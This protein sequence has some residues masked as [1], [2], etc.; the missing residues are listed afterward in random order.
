MPDKQAEYRI[1]GVDVVLLHGNIA[2]LPHRV[3]VIVSSDD[4]YLS[5]GG[6][7]SQAIWAAA[8]PDFADEVAGARENQT[9][10]LGGV[11]VTPAGQLNANEIIHA[12]TIDLDRLKPIGPREARELYG[13]VV[14]TACVLSHETVALP[15]LGTGS[16]RLDVEGSVKALADALDERSYE[17]IVL[18]RVFLVVFSED[19]FK[20]CDVHLLPRAGNHVSLYERLERSRRA[21]GG[22]AAD[23]IGEAWNRFIQDED[24]ATYNAVRLLEAVMDAAFDIALTLARANAGKLAPASI[25][26]NQDLEWHEPAGDDDSPRGPRLLHARLSMGRKLSTVQDLVIAAGDALPGDLL[27]ETSI[28]IHNRNLLVHSMPDTEFDVLVAQRAFLSAIVQWCDWIFLTL[29]DRT[30]WEALTRRHGEVSD[31]RGGNEAREHGVVDTPGADNANG[32]AATVTY[33]AG[34]RLLAHA[35]QPDSADGDESPTETCDP[36]SAMK[37]SRSTTTGT[38]HVRQLHR[39]LLD[40]LDPRAL[41]ALMAQLRAEGYRGKDQDCLLEYCVR[42]DDP[43]RFVA[44]QF[45]TWQLREQLQRR[46]GVTSRADADNRGMA[47]QMLSSF[48]F[49]GTGAPRGL[50]WVDRRLEHL[51]GKVHASGEAELKG[52]VLECGAWL[53]YCVQILLRFVSQAAY[54]K[55]AELL[56]KENAWVKQ[57][58]KPLH[59]LSLGAL[60][61]VLEKLARRIEDDDSGKVAEFGKDFATHRLLPKGS[62]RIAQLR[63]GFAHFQGLA[64]DRPLPEKR[65]AAVLFFA[66]AERFLAHLGDPEHRIFPHI[67]TIDR[68]Q[69]DRHG[70][71][72]ILATSDEGREETVFCEDE[73]QPGELYY[74]HP[75]TNPLRVDP[76]LVV[77]A[78]LASPATKKRDD[79]E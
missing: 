21:V 9:A 27:R 17:D 28:A 30:R 74:M 3:D 65:A 46:T 14:D 71:R 77:A 76:I 34:V 75:L 66:E 31:G 43:V 23:A 22:A 33:D 4:N 50:R 53:E 61:D 64:D 15:L 18:E 41:E 54:D 40:E 32:E 39:Y 19:V 44:D 1:G 26:R 58:W 12:I 37:S 63:N 78:E 2:R 70:R 8:G 7:V 10:R 42:M 24:Q 49:P 59:K 35:D 11:V 56:V 62:D 47:A 16:A 45:A 29:P 5:H 51:A 52:L 38:R 68:I 6:G 67:L 20:R 79:E 25:A 13:K 72:T 55:P 48:G 60:L 73:L 69:I 57:A 36:P